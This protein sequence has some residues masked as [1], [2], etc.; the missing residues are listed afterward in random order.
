[1]A[2][3]QCFRCA[4]AANGGCEP[5]VTDAADCSDDGNGRVAAVH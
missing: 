3:T 5:K 4:S 2:A 1:V